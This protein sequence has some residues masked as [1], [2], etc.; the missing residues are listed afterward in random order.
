MKVELGLGLALVPLSSMDHKSSLEMDGKIC[1]NREVRMGFSSYIF[2]AT[3][4]DMVHIARHVC[5][6]MVVAEP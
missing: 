6:V 4:M 1:A 2:C 3:M 5:A